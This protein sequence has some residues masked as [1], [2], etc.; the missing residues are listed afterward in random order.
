LIDMPS[1][2]IRRFSYDTETQTLFVTFVDG[3]A[4]AYRGVPD[5]VHAAMGRAVSKGRF[6]AER[7]RGL[8]AYARMPPP[9]QD[10]PVLFTPP[11][12]REGTRGP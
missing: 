2:A 11:D 6:F 9:G 5:E 3:D 8:Y 4:Y 1:T 10:A 7:I 12:A